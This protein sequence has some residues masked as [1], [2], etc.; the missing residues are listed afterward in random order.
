MT[1]AGIGIVRACLAAR[2]PED[3]ERS[4]AEE[5]LLHAP[6]G[7]GG[8]DGGGMQGCDCD[9]VSVVPSNGTVKWDRQAA[10]GYWRR[11]WEIVDDTAT[12]AQAR[13]AE[14][15]KLPAF[16]LK[17]AAKEAGVPPLAIGVPARTKEETI[18]L[19]P[20]LEAGAG[21]VAGAQP[22]SVGSRVCEQSPFVF[23]ERRSTSNIMSGDDAR[24]PPDGK[25]GAVGP[26]ATSS[27][28][29]AAAA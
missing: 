17:A 19:I 20:Q 23:L 7:G 16:K 10:D 15:E 25:L 5:A 27:A 3:T 26:A 4:A 14:L 28:A 12:I 8:G 1:C 2:R 6:C 11:R 9:P 22:V 13:N 24:G 29:A 21:G 18:A